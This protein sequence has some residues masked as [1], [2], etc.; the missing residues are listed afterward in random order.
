MVLRGFRYSMKGVGRFSGRMRWLGRNFSAS[1]L[2]VPSVWMNIVR[3]P[4]TLG[5]PGRVERVEGTE[6]RDPA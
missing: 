6:G 5:T 2:G 3:R 1:G 4:R